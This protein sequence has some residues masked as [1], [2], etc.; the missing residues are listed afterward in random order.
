VRTRN[1][2]LASTAFF[3]VGPFLE[4]GV[5]PWLVSGFERGHGAIDV[6]ALRLLGVLLIAGGAVVVL[7]CFVHFVRDGGGTPSPLAPPARLVARG[8]YALVRNPMYL[9]TA[10]IIFGEGLALARPL[11]LI[12]AAVYLAA[13]AVLVWRLEEPLLARRHGPDWAAY[14]RAVPRWLPRVTTLD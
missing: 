10:A 8:P 6:A 2:A 3:F 11:L 1:A 13:M 5:G 4:A 9:A 7:W 12:C 14:A